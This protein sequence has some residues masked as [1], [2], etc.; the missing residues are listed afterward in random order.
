MRRQTMGGAGGAAML[1]TLWISAAVFVIDQVTK[2]LA[3]EYLAGRPPVKIMPGFDLQLAYNT[4]AAFGTLNDAGGWQNAFLIV[5][6]ALVSLFLVFSLRR[7][8]RTQ[9]QIAVSYSLILGGALGNVFDRLRQGYV[10]D[11]IHWFYKSYSWPN[12]NIADSAICIGAAL[13]ILDLVGA[14]FMGRRKAVEEER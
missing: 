14:R 11:F 3:V 7:L 5:V 8:S 10:V 1:K 12:F 9:L 4:G 2:W 13:L 6:A